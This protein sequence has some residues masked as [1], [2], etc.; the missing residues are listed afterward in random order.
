MVENFP[1]ISKVQS[2]R[3]NNLFN[4][5]HDLPKD[6]MVSVIVPVRN[7]AFSLVSMLDALRKQFDINGISL[8]P[9]LY[10]VL[11][12]ANNC[13][14]NSAAL[15]NHYKTAY[16]N[17]PLFIEE[18]KLPA[19]R[20]NIGVVR[21]ILMDAAF[22]R[23][24]VSGNKNGIIAST[25]GD[26]V[27]DNKWI[28][29]I[30]HEIE[31]GN[32]AVGGRILTTSAPSPFRLY[33][34]R[35]V[36]HKSLLANAESII[37][38]ATNNPWPSHFQ[39]FGASLA[40]TCNM[41]ERAGRLP[42]VP[43]LEDNAFLDALNSIDAKVRRSNQVKVYTSTRT[44]GR[45]PIGFSEQLNVWKNLAASSATQLAEPA[46]ASIIKL[47]N[48]AALRNYR[49]HFLQTNIHTPHLKNVAQSLSIKHVWL[50]QQ[51]EACNYF[52]ALWQKVEQNMVS[53]TWSKKWQAVPI[54]NAI[55]DLRLFISKARRV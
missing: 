46:D 48:R 29:T 45:V 24:K 7:E 55:H 12:L 23:L 2:S 28:S 34:L 51:L 8:N 36:M 5:Q 52:G 13:T 38:P 44:Q 39:Y 21:R 41:Y 32:D 42:Q 37:D 14:D 4:V 22:M 30:I 15:L 11:V 33:H 20:A 43:Y 47:Q 26:S 16:P 31:K 53:G 6:L 54:T 3:E 40:V 10:E 18:I 35:N 50:Q 19:A 17:F 1:K 9:N 25:D 49:N 27:V